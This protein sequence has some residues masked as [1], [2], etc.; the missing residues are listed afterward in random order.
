MLVLEL[1]EI[2]NNRLMLMVMIMISLVVMMDVSAYIFCVNAWVSIVSGISETCWMLPGDL[3]MFFFVV[4]MIMI[5]VVIVIVIVIQRH[6]I[7][8]AKSEILYI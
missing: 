8:L 4:I 5:I 2:K 3:C 7:P 6:T 1:V